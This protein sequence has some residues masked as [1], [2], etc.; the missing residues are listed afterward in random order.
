M[1]AYGPLYVW[2]GRASTSP[3][4]GST[5]VN[6]GK[7]N[8]GSTERQ[9][10]EIADSSSNVPTG[11]TCPSGGMSGHAVDRLTAR[12]VGVPRSHDGE[13]EFTL[14]VAF[15][16]DVGISPGSLREDAL[17]VTGGTVTQAQ[18]VDDRSDLFEITVEPASDEDDGLG[19]CLRTVASCMKTGGCPGVPAPAI[20][21]PRRMHRRRR[22]HSSKC[23]QAS[24]RNAPVITLSIG[25]S[26]VGIA[27][28]NK[29]AAAQSAKM[30]ALTPGL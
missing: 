22:A 17:T 21:P 28:M 3:E 26:P 4:D 19:I 24:V 20:P 25:L 11:R 8:I 18:R 1:S 13:S 27:S 6:T 14:R 15:I 10:V 23:P 30:T 29:I 2:L 16:K 12:F 7:V 9:C 5:V